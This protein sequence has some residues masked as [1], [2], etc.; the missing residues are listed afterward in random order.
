[1]RALQQGYGVNEQELLSNTLLVAF[2]ATL[3]WTDRRWVH[4]VVSVLCFLG[5]A[6]S[7]VRSVV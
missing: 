1:V 5:I 2:L 4:A 7:T 3:I 6:V